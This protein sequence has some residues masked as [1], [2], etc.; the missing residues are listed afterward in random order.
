MKSKKIL[1]LT[2]IY[3]GPDLEHG[4]P[5]IH[6]FTREWIKMGYEVTVFHHQVVYPSIFY[7]IARMFREK[8]ASLTG[9][10]VFTKK[11]TGDKFYLMDGVKVHRNPIF[12]RIPHGRF[13]KKTIRRQIEKILEFNKGNEFEPD[14]IIGHFSNPQLEIIH[15]LK[16]IYH[17]RTCLV[18]H[19]IGNSIKK[20]YHS[21]YR[22]LMRSIDIWGYRSK[23]IKLGFE[24]NFEEKEHSFYCYSGIP[25]NYITKINNRE[26]IGDLKR[27]IYIGE[28]IKRKHPIALVNSIHTVY[29]EQGFNITYVGKGA[30]EDIIRKR[31]SLLNIANSVTFE[32]FI[33][34]NEILSKLDESDCMIMI[35]SNETFG[36]VYLEAMGR[37]CITIGSINEGIDGVIR[38]GVNGFLCKAGDEKE[39]TKLIRHINSLSQKEKKQIS[40]N[41]ISTVDKLTDFKA[42]LNYIKAINN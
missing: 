16:K 12:K 35:S 28:F 41:A 14:I 25:E 39:L 29:Q 31:I 33:S 42:A 40:Q 2:T 19:D 27:F 26:F 13:T 17:S 38:H 5:A 1:L 15:N 3:P 9:A 30:E 32:G 4:T 8:I 22:E 24:N 34:R 18:M 20:I 7:L 23:P 21:N 10:V 11:D 6:Y 37:G 36:L